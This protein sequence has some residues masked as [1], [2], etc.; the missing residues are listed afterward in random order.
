MIPRTPPTHTIHHR[1]LNRHGVVCE[2]VNS[3]CH[4]ATDDQARQVFDAHCVHARNAWTRGDTWN[5][6]PVRIVGIHLVDANG[7]ELAAW[8]H[9]AEMAVA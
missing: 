5:G 4:G 8:T 3:T 1:Y 2:R 7:I 6:V 9:K